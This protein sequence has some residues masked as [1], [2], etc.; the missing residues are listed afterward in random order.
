MNYECLICQVK[1][2]QKRMDKYEIPE[3]KRN[4]LVSKMIKE[5]AEIDL[6]SSYSPEVTRNILGKLEQNS[7]ISD[8][9]QIEK[10]ESNRELLI[11]YEEFKHK[12]KNSENPFDTALRLAIAGNIIDFGHRV[13]CDRSQKA[14]RFGEIPGAGAG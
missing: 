11:R 6:D 2:L 3:D 14:A 9:Y 13:D 10:E 4:G 1:A 8:P 7:S 12:V 5:I